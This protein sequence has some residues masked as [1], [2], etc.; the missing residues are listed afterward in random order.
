MSHN[1]SNIRQISKAGQSELLRIQGDSV[2]QKYI[3]IPAVLCG[4]IFHP[5]LDTLTLTLTLNYSQSRP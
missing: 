4:L 2:T 3:V 5:H 1:Y